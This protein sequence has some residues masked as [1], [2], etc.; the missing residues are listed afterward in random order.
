MH[1]KMLTQE[2]ISNLNAAQ[3]IKSQTDEL[4]LA[5]CR[6]A[7][8]NSEALKRID[9]SESKI[10]KSVELI[11][12]QL[13]EHRNGVKN[14]MRTN[15]T[16]LSELKNKLKDD[17]LN[18]RIGSLKKKQQAL[19]DTVN[20]LKEKLSEANKKWH[21]LCQQIEKLKRNH[22]VLQH[23]V[24][25]AENGNEHSRNKLDAHNFNLNKID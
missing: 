5:K 20:L 21:E 16:S 22:R 18:K 25:A 4:K 10:G 24:S 13:D 11:R 8:L 1:K 23:I 12:C 6:L 17:L 7:D 19:K 15:V 2:Q 3:L 14:W 9:F